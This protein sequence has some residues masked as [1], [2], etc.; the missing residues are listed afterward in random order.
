MLRI[1]NGRVFDPTNGVHGEVRDI[2]I[3]GGKIVAGPLAPAAT[4]LDA[5][6]CAVLPG[7][8]EIHSHV[9]GPK[10]NNGRSM[11]PEDHAD[12]VRLHTDVT[13]AGCGYTI[14]TTFMTGYEYAQLGYTTLFEAAVP[15]LTA[16]H[17]HEELHDIPIVDAGCYTVMGNNYLILK[18]LSDPD[19]AR[20]AERLREVVAWLLQATKG[21]AVKIVNPGGVENWKWNQGVTDLDTQVPPFGVTP[22]Q[23]VTGLAQA[24]EELGL[25]HSIH[26]HGNHLGEPGNVETT[27]ATMRALAGRRVHFTHLQFHSYDV[28]PRGG[29][30]SGA[31]RVAQ[32]LDEH[33]EFTSDVGQLVFGPAT[34]MT[35]DA[36]MEFR[37]HHLQKHKWLNVDV[38]MESGAGVVPMTYRPGA[39]VNAVQWCVGLELLLLARN[40]WQI[41]LTTDHPNAGPFVAYPLIIRLLMDLDFRRTWLDRIHPQARQ[42]TCLHELT[43]VY[44]LEEIA[45]ITRSGPARA[46]R[47]PDKGHLGPS[48]DADVAVYPLHDDKQHMFSKPTYVIKGGNVVVRDGEVVDSFRGKV[49]SVDLAGP[50]QL[51]ADLAEYFEQYSTVKLENYV[52]EDEYVPDLQ[53]VACR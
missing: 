50:R 53:L 38:E 47:L 25:P 39:L 32:C 11:C 37:L 8:V 41:F 52:V 29:Y 35:S 34:T 19:E 12:H 17:A 14:P 3:D 45:V 23:I 36:P 18:A 27:L 33:P 42:L 51:P 49:L 1:T 4:T 13:R 7:G 20:R 16:R 24:V 26:L 46:L 31:A 30:A 9:A 15:P 43:R 22:R 6:G 21:Y 40:P 44:T 10:V 48:A 28:S 2:W 5:A